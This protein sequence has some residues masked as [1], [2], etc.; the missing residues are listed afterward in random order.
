MEFQE[1]AESCV[2]YKPGFLD[3]LEAAS[4]FEVLR[5]EVPWRQEVLKFSTKEVNLPRLVSWH[6]DPGANYYYSG[7]QNVPL[8][9][10][11][12][13][14]SLKQKCDD[15]FPAH[16]FNS[17]LLNY[18]RCG[19]DSIGD[20]CDNERDLVDNST[21][22]TISL[23]ATRRFH[24]KSKTTGEIKKVDVEAGSL[25]LMYG[26]CQKLWLHGINKDFNVTEP[27]ISLTFRTV[28]I[29]SS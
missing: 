19:A 16:K 22:A 20:H 21:I 11:N 10:T 4:Y 9:W 6:G 13:L 18:Y 24:L 1:I 5:T 8:Q 14:M 27:R 25:L 7:I 26:E 17:V 29:I 28:R 23:G 3:P 2:A 12:T 15:L